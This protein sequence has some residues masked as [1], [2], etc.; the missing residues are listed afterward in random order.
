M[1]KF[2]YIALVATIL[3]SCK[4]KKNT[5]ESGK[6]SLIEITSKQFEAENMAIG[7]LEQRF[8]EEVINAKGY[9]I[10]LPTGRAQV[11]VVVAGTVQK[12]H[13]SEGQYVSQKQPLI[14]IAGS[15][16]IDMQK[17]FAEASARLKKIKSEYERSKSLL[18]DKLDSQK[19]FIAIES[20]YKAS[21]AQYAALKLKLSATGLQTTQI[22]N[23]SITPSYQIN[24]PISGYISQLNISLGQF[25]D[26][27]TP[28]MEIINTHNLQL[29]LSVFA[30]NISTIKVGQKVKYKLNGKEYIASINHIGN[31]VNQESK[32]VE[33]YAHIDNAGNV[34]K[35]NN[36][37]VDAQIVTYTERITSLPLEALLKSEN[38]YFFFVLDKKENGNY[39][40]HK[41]E[42][43]IGRKN[44]EFAEILNKNVNGKILIKGVYN[45][46]AE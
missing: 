4:N 44:S 7:N 39:Y 26:K 32:A 17:D 16:I 45:I 18:E 15:D 40:F 35:I 21:L 2:I 41:V 34:A 14:T 22:E 29:K 8:F 36:A 20:E 28:I 12:I 43:N 3:I 1:R 42:A 38:S 11:S 25:L 6:N 27:Q 37:Y 9:I 30:D 19:G 33:C 5:V 10:P 23:G 24:S 13:C 31:T 46:N